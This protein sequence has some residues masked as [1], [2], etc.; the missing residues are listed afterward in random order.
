MWFVVYGQLT[1]LF[2]CFNPQNLHAAF[3]IVTTVYKIGIRVEKGS[4]WGHFTNR[5]AKQ[6]LGLW[7]EY[8]ITS[9]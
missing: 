6:A 7:R 4:F 1:A 2:L 9:T 3:V 8:L 5:L